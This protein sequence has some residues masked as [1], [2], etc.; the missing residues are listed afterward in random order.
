MVLI[1]IGENV[2]PAKNPSA[3]DSA[4]SSATADNAT[5]PAPATD[6]KSDWTKCSDNEDLVNNYSDWTKV[7][8]ECKEEAN[9]EAKYGTPEW[10]WLP[11]GSFLKGT[12]YSTSGI[13]TAIEADAQF[14]NGFGAMVHSTVTCRYDLR[15]QKVLDVSILPH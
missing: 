14:Q 5:T 10:P 11:F 15:A 9:S 6:C 2:D 12:D 7:Q 4:A 13:A 3:S 1:V 8:V